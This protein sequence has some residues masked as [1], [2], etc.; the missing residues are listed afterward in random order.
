MKTFLSKWGHCLLGLYLLIYLPCFSYLEAHITEDYAGLHNI[1]CPIDDMIP[2]CEYFIIPYYIWFAF[3]AA[4]CVYFFFSSQGECVR[5]GLYLIVGMSIAVAIYFI[6]PNGLI[7]FRP[8]SYP[9][10]NIFTDLV[11]NLHNMDTSTNVFPSL[12]VY[13]TLAVTVAVFESKTFKKH[14]TL[15]KIIT[16]VLAVLILAST[17]FLKQHSIYDMFAAIVLAAALYPVF[18][19][20]KVFRKFKW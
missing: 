17:L 3:I 19:K 16:S 8:T 20:T 2:F 6:Y 7:D 15:V 10:D 12:H 1:H 5:M 4:A 13:N 11:I 9:R 14:H 18:Y